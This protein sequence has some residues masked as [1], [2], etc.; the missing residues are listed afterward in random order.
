MAKFEHTVTA[1]EAAHYDAIRQ[2]RGWSWA[3][4]AAYFETCS[5]A[6]PTAPFFAEWA[7]GQEEAP[8]SRRAKKGTER[9]T[10]EAPE[11]R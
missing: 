1:D 10:T 11:T 2:Q 6:D 3:T 9:A 5:P 4:L 8:R 7:R